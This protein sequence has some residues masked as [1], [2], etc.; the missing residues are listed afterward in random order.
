MAKSKK[1]II[2]EAVESLGWSV[3]F[4]TQKNQDGKIEKYV[5][6]SGYSDAGEDIEFIEFYD[7]L[8]EIPEK[9]YERYQDFDVDEHVAMWLEAK[10]NGTSGVPDARVL[11]K[12]AEWTEQFLLKL[13]EA[14]RDALAGKKPTA[15]KKTHD[16]K[17]QKLMN[18]IELQDRVHHGVY[19]AWDTINS[20]INEVY[21]I[22]IGDA[23]VLW[24]EQKGA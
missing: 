17:L 4:D 11:V 2:E 20:L 23:L 3:T 12:D 19:E 21:G 6:V 8:D 22:D 13:S 9:F 18:L 16:E 5:A 10:Q 1:K 14:L 24:E 15:E 7:S